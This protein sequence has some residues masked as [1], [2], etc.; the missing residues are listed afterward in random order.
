MKF[1]TG[2]FIL[3][4]FISA[5]SYA[6]DTSGCAQVVSELKRLDCYDQQARL[7]NEE[8]ENKKTIS[9]REAPQIDVTPVQSK[10]ATIDEKNPSFFSRPDQYSSEYLATIASVDKSRSKIRVMLSNDQVWQLQKSRLITF[11]AGDRVV[12]KQG[13][14]GGYTMRVNAGGSHRVKRID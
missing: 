10:P 9:A 6:H 11:K 14:I 12:V 13:L 4:C 1:M 5:Q 8:V 2:T 7:T 3:L